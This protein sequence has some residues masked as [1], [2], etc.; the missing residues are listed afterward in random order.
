MLK[1]VPLE[2]RELNVLVAELHRHHKPVRGHRFCIGVEDNGRLVGGCAVGRP[3]AR[4]A[5]SPKEVLEVTRLVTD[6]TR[7]ACSM[8]YGAAARIGK[9]LGYRRIQTYIL[10]S[11]N[12][13]SLRASGWVLE[14]G[15]CGGG[16]WSRVGRPRPD[17]QPAE[18]KQRW[19]KS[20]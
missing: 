13:A 3:V 18:L 10:A 8:L 12:G 17:T 7:N 20:L 5:G 2:L 16:P 4:L 6:G 15:Q 11:E 14:D 1:I 19:A 9:E